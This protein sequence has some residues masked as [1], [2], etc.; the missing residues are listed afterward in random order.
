ML[1][2]SPKDII[3]GSSG[4]GKSCFRLVVTADANVVTRHV[5]QSDGMFGK[6]ARTS[7]ARKSE[8]FSC[9]GWTRKSPNSPLGKSLPYEPMSGSP[10][11][12]KFREATKRC[13]VPEGDT[14][15]FACYE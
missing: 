11:A 5:E 2:G 10:T 3:A 4:A 6:N 1:I 7:L 14:V 15:G 9:R 8:K 12:T 13:D